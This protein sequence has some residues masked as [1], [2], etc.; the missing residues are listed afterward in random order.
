[1]LHGPVTAQLFPAVCSKENAGRCAFGMSLEN[2]VSC[3]V[4]RSLQRETSSALSL[5]LGGEAVLQ[6]GS[7]RAGEREILGSG[8][9]GVAG[10]A[11]ASSWEA[12]GKPLR[13]P[14]HQLRLHEMRGFVGALETRKGKVRKCSPE[15]PLQRAFWTPPGTFGAQPAAG[16][17]E[18]Q[19]PGSSPLTLVPHQRQSQKSIPISPSFT[20]SIPDSLSVG[21]FKT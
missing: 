19:C 12:A 18:R 3:R 9:C 7:S 13:L 1:M 16:T 2:W 14:G 10:S 6:A 17:L 21:P 11:S 8:R 15:R 4:S 5:R 20:E